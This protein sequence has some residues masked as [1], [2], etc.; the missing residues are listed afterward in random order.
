MGCH[1]STIASMQ[2]T[3]AD[4]AVLIRQPDS[5][6]GAFAPDGRQQPAH[7]EK[8]VQCDACPELPSQLTHMDQRVLDLQADRSQLHKEILALR[9]TNLVQS[10]ELA[11]FEYQAQDVD[12]LRKWCAT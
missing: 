9:R 8:T 7:S 11:E 12:A 5:K 10:F 2:V 1:G 6:A 4:E 3:D